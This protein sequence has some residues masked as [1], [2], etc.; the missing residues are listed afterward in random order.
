M[1][2]WTKGAAAL[3]LATFATF[4]VADVRSDAAA[5]LAEAHAMVVSKGLKDG[6]A[7]INAGGKWKRGKAYVVLVNFDGGTLLAHADNPK[8]AGKAMLEAKD[9]SGKAFVQETIRNVKATGD[10]LVE[11]RWA[12]PATQK[13][14]NG[15]LMAKRV[16]GQ[17][18]YI[19]VGFWE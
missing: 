11:Y 1:N 12:N 9:A 3:A 6:A 15:R 5:M 17:D 18:T 2:T 19:A 16:P 10:S 14:D 13:I 4:G 8:M 7:E